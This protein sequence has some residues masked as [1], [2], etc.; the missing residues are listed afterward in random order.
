MGLVVGMRA[1]VSVRV[2]VMSAVV[3]KGWGIEWKAEY[4]VD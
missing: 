1:V 4:V 2:R 3:A